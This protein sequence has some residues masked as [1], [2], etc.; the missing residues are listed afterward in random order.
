MLMVVL[1]RE[2]PTFFCYNLAAATHAP[3]D[4]GTR[5]NLTRCVIFV[6]SGIIVLPEIIRIFEDGHNSGEV[7]RP[8]RLH[9][10][11]SK[12]VWT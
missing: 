10:N 7:T 3:I 4:T 1:R 9:R 2:L 5:R 11:T 6:E 12:Y 8:A